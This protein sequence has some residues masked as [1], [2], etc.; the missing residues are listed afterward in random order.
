MES[1]RVLLIATLLVLA[2]AGYFVYF[3]EKPPEESGPSEPDQP[4]EH[5]LSGFRLIENFGEHKKW[6][7]TSGEAERR[8]GEVKLNDPR[9]VYSE[10][11][12]TRAVL[13]AGRGTYQVGEKILKLSAGVVVERLEKE[14]VLETNFLK[15]D[16]EAGILSTEAKIELETSRGVF[17]AR[18]LWADL[19]EEE[20][21]LQSEVEF[22]AR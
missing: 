15:W 16:R 11:G 19:N 3:Q 22:Q 4:V 12:E 13:T 1:R 6:V 2:G 5:S 10:A 8:A 21:K 14:Q 20:L 9:V 7:L 17:T 18:G